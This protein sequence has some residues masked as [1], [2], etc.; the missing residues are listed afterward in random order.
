MNKKDIKEI[1]KRN[2][3]QLGAGSMEMILEELNKKVIYMAR[4]CK[5]GNIKRLTPETFWIALGNWAQGETNGMG[6]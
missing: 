3:I 4:K 1:F 5:N 6:K 2:G